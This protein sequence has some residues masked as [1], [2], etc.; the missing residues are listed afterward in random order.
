MI[1]RLCG[2]ALLTAFAAMVLKQYK[3]E[4]A[5]PVSVAGGVLLLLAIIA[6]LAPQVEYISGLWYADDFGEYAAPLVKSLGVALIAQ[7]ASDVCRDMGET[8]A[9]SKVELAGKAEI[10]LLCLPLIGELLGFARELLL[11]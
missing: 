7:T 2:V 8:S 10:M 4:L 5:L 6:R 3:P 1:F 11:G 9:A